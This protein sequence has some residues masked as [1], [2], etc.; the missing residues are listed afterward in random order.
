MCVFVCV[1]VKV[2][3]ILIK[4]HLSFCYTSRKRAFSLVNII[5]LQLKRNSD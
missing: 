5:M 4:S 1:Y 2:H 3:S